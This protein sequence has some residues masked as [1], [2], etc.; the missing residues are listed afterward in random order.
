[1][2]E[3]VEQSV[4]NDEDSFVNSYVKSFGPEYDKEQLNFLLRDFLVAGS[5]T[6]L[7]NTSMGSNILSKSSG[8]A[9]AS[10]S[11]GKD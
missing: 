7:N 4:R 11:S 10:K 6:T 1:L 8:M 2:E 5:E 9:D 3:Y